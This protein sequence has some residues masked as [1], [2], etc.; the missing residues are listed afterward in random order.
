MTLQEL[1]NIPH[2]L[3]GSRALGI[4]TE[5]SDYDLLVHITDLPNYLLDRINCRNLSIERYFNLLPK[6]GKGHILRRQTRASGNSSV[7]LIVLTHQEDINIIKQSMEDLKQCPAYMLK[8]KHIRIALFE[9]S[10]KHYGFTEP[11]EAILTEI[12]Y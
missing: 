9:S 2:T 11:I 7:D 4:N 1:L 8:E 3:I 10:L 12:P 5:K 6:Y